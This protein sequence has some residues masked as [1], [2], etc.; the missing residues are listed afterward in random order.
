MT[1]TLDAPVTNPRALLPARLFDRMVRR[2]AAEH[3][4]HAEQ[5]G[6][7]VDQA[8]A[9]LAA[10]AARPDE[11]LSPSPKVDI[12]WHTF[13]LYT[14]PYAQFCDQLAGHFIHHVPDDDPAAVRVSGPATIRRT[15]AVMREL[16]LPVVEDLWRDAA[17]CS[18]S[19]TGKC[20][21]CHE[22]CT[23]STSN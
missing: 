9:F 2:V 12:G 6:Q 17:D 20:S 19:G 4:E 23:D 10:C 18:G 21:Q 22:G 16:G 7:I 14:R 5:A 1:I 13:I 8:L 3:P 11:P 15:V